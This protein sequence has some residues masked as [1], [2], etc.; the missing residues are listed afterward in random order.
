MMGQGRGLEMVRI[1]GNN[2]NMLLKLAATSMGLTLAN[3]KLYTYCLTCL[4]EAKKDVEFMQILE[5]AYIS[6]SVEDECFADKFMAVSA[7]AEK[8]T[9]EL[10]QCQI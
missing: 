1:F 10:E 8:I 9:L 6:C 5:Q 4:Q 7:E 2:P 3:A